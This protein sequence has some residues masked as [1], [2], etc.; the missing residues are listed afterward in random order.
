MVANVKQTNHKGEYVVNLQDGKAGIY[1]FEQNK[2]CCETP[3][4]N[5]KEGK[6]SD[7]SE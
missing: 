5:F 6:D 2:L 7:S 1:I 3:E 4:E